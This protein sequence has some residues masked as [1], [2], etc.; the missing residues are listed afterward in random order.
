MVWPRHSAAEGWRERERDRTAPFRYALRR[1]RA[2]QGQCGSDAGGCMGEGLRA[3]A[4]RLAAQR[5]GGGRLR[6]RGN[7]AG[8]GHTRLGCAGAGRRRASSACRQGRSETACLR[9]RATTQ[10]SA[11]PAGRP[12][13][14]RSRAGCPADARPTKLGTTP[15]TKTRTR[16]PV[17][18]SRRLSKRLL[19]MVT[20]RRSG[21]ADGDRNAEGLSTL[22]NRLRSARSKFTPAADV[23]PVLIRGFLQTTGHSN[24]LIPPPTSA[25]AQNPIQSS[26]TCALGRV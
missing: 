19:A 15:S 21:Q 4:V 5:G 23:T 1:R 26:S 24:T 11:R 18:R 7:A 25:Q 6:G 20:R 2:V 17:N 16:S 3:G 8:A 12:R 22:L 9:S 13:V 14:G 10:A